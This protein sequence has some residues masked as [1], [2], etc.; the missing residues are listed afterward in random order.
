SESAR[1]SCSWAT[2]R[3][4]AARAPGAGT[5]RQGHRRSE[6]HESEGDDDVERRQSAPEDMDDEPPTRGGDDHPDEAGRQRPRAAAG[7]LRRE[8]EREPEP[9]EAVE[10][11]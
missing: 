3:R 6:Q 10:R 8:V 11:P 2:F 1:A 5:D 4:A 7:A 9:E